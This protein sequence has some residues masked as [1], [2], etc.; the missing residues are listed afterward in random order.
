MHMESYKKLLTEFS[1]TNNGCWSKQDPV[2]A[3]VGW[4]AF[5]SNTMQ[6]LAAFDDEKARNPGIDSSSFVFRFSCVMF[7]I[8]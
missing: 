1:K 7:F 3:W 5:G 6:Q 8:P 2:R 4:L